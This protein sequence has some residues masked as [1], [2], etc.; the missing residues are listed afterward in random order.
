[1]LVHGL[2]RNETAEADLERIEQLARSVLDAPLDHMPSDERAAAHSTRYELEQLLT[3]LDNREASQ[4]DLARWE[5]KWLPFISDGKR[6]LK[7]LQ[8]ELA[9]DPDLFV[10]LL[11]FLYRPS[12]QDPDTADDPDPQA[13]T[14]AHLAFRLL[15]AWKQIPGLDASAGS[16]GEAPIDD[17]L[18]PIRAANAGMVDE[19]MLFS[20]VQRATEL[21][22]EA[23]RSEMCHQ[24]IGRQL[25]YAPA[26]PDG[27]WPCTP[28]RKLIEA[29]RN[30][31]VDQGMVVGVI[32][33]R[34][35]HA[36]GHDGAQERTM[37]KR[38]REWC[39]AVRLKQPR[40]GTILRRL[41]EHYEDEARREAERGRLEEFG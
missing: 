23:K 10:E 36:A 38:F 15:D 33:R 8:A 41:A 9:N 4:Q 18:R 22:T 30:D 39:E 32:N 24:T 29:L 27:I 12:D 3:F 37:A 31:D 14:R 17:G 35:V 2:R 6:G 1:M 16:I 11:K 28:V 21:A 34:G 19:Q 13:E 20:W 7:A 25:A 40:T 5:W 26:D